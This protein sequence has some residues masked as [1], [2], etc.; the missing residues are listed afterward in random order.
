MLADCLALSVGVSGEIY[1]VGVFCRFLQFSNDALVVTL[2]GVGD[3]FVGRLEVVLDINAQS[4]G[5]QI[6]DMAYRSFNKIVLSQVFIYGL[7]LRRRFNY[8]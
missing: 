8:Y 6:F 7:R 4:F 5:R 1:G 2:F 3:Y